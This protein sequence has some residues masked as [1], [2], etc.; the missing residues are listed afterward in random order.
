MRLDFHQLIELIQSHA[1]A[2]LVVDHK[3]ALVTVSLTN[4]EQLN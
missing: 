1:V 4:V 2:C 3:V